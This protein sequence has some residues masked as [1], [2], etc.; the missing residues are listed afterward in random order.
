MFSKI[1]VAVDRSDTSQH[2]FNKAI[3]FA[4]A[5]QGTIMLIHVLSPMDENYPKPIF[6]IDSV[7]T[8]LK[9]EAIKSHFQQWEELEQEGLTFLRNLTAQATAAGIPTEFTQSLGHPGQ[10]ICVLA[11]TWEADLIIMGRRGRAGLSELFLGSMSNYVL[12]HAPCSVLTV[13][14]AIQS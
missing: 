4:K 11:R 1:I 12:H 7:Y 10:A 5:V 8:R 2:A 14:G 3:A 13:Q 9:A 6:P